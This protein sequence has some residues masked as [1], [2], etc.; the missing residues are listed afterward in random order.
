MF[1]PLRFEPVIAPVAATDDGVIAPK[2][3]VI[4]GVV[5]PV[6]TTPDTPFAVVTATDVT[7][8]KADQ[9]GLAGVPVFTS[10]LLSVVLN[11]SKPVAGNTIAFLFTNVIRGASKPFAVE[12]KSRMEELSGVIVPTPNCAYEDLA[13]RNK[14]NNN[15]A[16]TNFF[17]LILSP[18][19]YIKIFVLELGFA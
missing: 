14:L 18:V 10:K 6:A 15:A 17:I 3:K 5:E 13:E 1:V 12:V 11:I 9:T 8:P 4:A 2:V 7:V 16:L 19:L